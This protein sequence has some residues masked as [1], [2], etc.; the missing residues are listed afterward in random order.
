MRK[1]KKY[2]K[3]YVTF[4]FRPATIPAMMGVKT[5]KYAIRCESEEEVRYTL[6]DINSYDGVSYL[7]V[8]RCG[9]LPK[10]TKIVKITDAF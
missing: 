1:V 6:A 5:K 4:Q 2:F 7:R 8:N 10:G 9:K 3:A